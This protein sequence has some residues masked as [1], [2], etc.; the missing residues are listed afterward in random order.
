ML[1]GLLVLLP[2]CLALQSIVNTTNG[3]IEGA[4]SEYGLAWKGESHCDYLEKG[5]MT[6]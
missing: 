3:P 5:Q 6:A 2:A 4:Q 1:V